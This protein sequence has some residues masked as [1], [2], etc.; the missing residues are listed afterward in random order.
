[1]VGGYCGLPHSVK[2]WVLFNFP[3]HWWGMSK[4]LCLVIDR[5]T[6]VTLREYPEV[7][8]EDWYKARK[9]VANSYAEEHGWGGNWYVDS[10]EI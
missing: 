7:L 10:L 2:K 1:M 4:F 9:Q 8:A 5:A 6:K 3:V